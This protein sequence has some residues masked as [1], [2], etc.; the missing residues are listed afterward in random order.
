MERLALLTYLTLGSILLDI[1]AVAQNH[2]SKKDPVKYHEVKLNGTYLKDYL[3]DTKDLLISP[4]R[5]KTRDWIKA[6]VVAGATLVI[7]NFDED[8][9]QWVA[10]KSTKTTGD[11]AN[12]M[13]PI[14][15]DRYLLPVA[16]MIPLFVYGAL[17]KNYKAR[18]AALLGV[19]SYVI[20]GIFTQVLKHTVRRQRPHESNDSFPS[21]HASSVFSIASVVA[22][23]YKDKKWVPPVVY[24]LASL[25]AI[26]RL[27][28]QAHW[29]SDIFFGSAMGYFIGKSL[30]RFHQD[31]E[32]NLTV[33]PVVSIDA[34]SIG[35]VYQF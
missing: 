13:E 25:T 1:S 11:L 9:N 4:L 35:I 17:G 22:T 29:A 34:N 28:K 30:V 12:A 32:S 10:S 19:E 21:G 16:T 18:K 27:H 14:G 6:S 24:S 31:K 5:W 7:W 3:I 33:F 15:N 20:T 2:R 26:S 23:I 8:I